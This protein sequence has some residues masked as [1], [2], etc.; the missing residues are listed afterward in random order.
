MVVTVLWIVALASSAPTVRG[1][2]TGACMPA[3]GADNFGPHLGQLAAPPWGWLP[4]VFEVQLLRDS[5]ETHLP[6]RMCPS[7]N[8]ESTEF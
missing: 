6:G 2:A 4:G 3:D 1:G 8:P 5:C 7:E